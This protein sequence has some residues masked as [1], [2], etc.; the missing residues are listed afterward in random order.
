MTVHLDLSYPIRREHHNA[1]VY[2]L[3][4]VAALAPALFA[5][6]LLAD[7]ALLAY[8]ALL[9]DLGEL[10]AHSVQIEVQAQ[11]LPT[12][13]AQLPEELLGEPHAASPVTTVPTAAA[14]QEGNC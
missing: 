13:A 3:Q 11:P 1:I 5:S 9:A 2:P 12:E 10:C 4:L 14:R 7:W 8:L 6:A